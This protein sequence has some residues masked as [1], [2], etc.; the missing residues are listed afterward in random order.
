MKKLTKKEFIEKAKKVHGEKYDYSK[1]E[2]I[3][4]RT[5]VCIIC[6]EHGEFW[7]TPNSH[8]SGD[9][10]KKCS[11]EK[12]SKCK[13]KKTNDFIKEAREIHGNKYDYSK[14]E[15]INTHTKVCIICPEHG[16][17]WQTP[18]HHL[19][20]HECKK[21][22]DIKKGKKIYNKEYFITKSNEVHNN[23]YDYSKVV[24][25]D[26]YT[27]VCITCKIHGDFFQAPYMHIFGQGCPK[28]GNYMKNKDR[29]KN[30]ED[31]I[32]DAKKVHG[33]KYD[34]SKVKYVNNHTKVCIICPEHGEFWQTPNRH[35]S[36]NGCPVCRE[37]KSEKE[38]ENM[39]NINGII[40]ER[41]KKFDWLG[42]QSIDFYIPS[43]NIG[44]ECQGIQH[45]FSS[46][47]KKSFYTV[48]KINE[49][50][51]RDSIKKELC[52]KN[53]IKLLYYSNFV[54]DFPY[55]VITDKNKLL[56]IIKDYV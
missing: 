48:E 15:Y 16:E 3:N 25:K 38:I 5:K 28:C 20:G 49:I 41:W 11:N 12:K 36:N 7:Q 32:K 4:S 46:K 42:K 8:L 37:S 39:L 6:P 54:I 22:S 27:K 52:E 13:S 45:F 18:S 30:V 50:Q 17:F 51:K 1:T 34:Y 53:G 29:T 24:Y 31:F 33:E 14:V 43:V 47:N 55:D 35:L 44:I 2:Y 9:G 26:N 19:G 23:K 10:C 21:C 56:K 40:H